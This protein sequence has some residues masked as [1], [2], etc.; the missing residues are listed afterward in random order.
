M[1]PE[2]SSNPLYSNVMI[3]NKDG[4]LEL[5]QVHDTPKQGCWSSRG[6]LIVGAGKGLKVFE[7]RPVDP[8]DEEGTRSTR[9]SRSRSA[10]GPLEESHS[11][12]RGIKLPAVSQPPPEETFG[13][14][15]SGVAAQLALSSMNKRA[16]SPSSFR[17]YKAGEPRSQSRTRP[18]GRQRS[19]SLAR[20]DAKS[21]NVAHVLE[22]DVSM[23]M[24]NRAIMGYGLSKVDQSLGRCSIAHVN[25]APG[26][27]RLYQSHPR[28]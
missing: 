18:S 27:Q 1:V 6:A 5:Y 13:A 12:G 15:R 20:Q 25:T 26:Q 4:D 7:G 11:R 9:I 8:T 14:P 10:T 17:K 21:R 16:Y 2:S 3:V 28:L 24:R 23:V 19:V 22:D